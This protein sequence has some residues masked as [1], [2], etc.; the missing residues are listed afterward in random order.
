M[1]L[2]EAFYFAE[3]TPELLIHLET[4]YGEDIYDEVIICLYQFYLEE[5][6]KRRFKDM[7]SQIGNIH[8]TIHAFKKFSNELNELLKQ[9]TYLELRPDIEELNTYLTQKVTQYHYLLSARYDHNSKNRLPKQE[10]GKKGKI[11]CPY[12]NIFLIKIYNIFKGKKADILEVDLIKDIVKLIYSLKHTRQLINARE[13]ARN[14]INHKGPNHIDDE[15][16]KYLIAFVE[17]RNAWLI[18][19]LFYEVDDKFITSKNLTERIREQKSKI[20]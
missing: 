6:F 1:T 13:I 7:K 3:V 11:G 12:F 10:K 5:S 9:S 8:K 15:Q 2:F 14:H 18:F 17:T 16:L 19:P 4:R 20:S